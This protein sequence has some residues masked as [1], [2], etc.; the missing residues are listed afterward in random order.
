MRCLLQDSLV[1]LYPDSE[2]GSRP[3][4]SFS[5]DVARGGI[6]ATTILINDARVG[7]PVRLA[8]APAPKTWSV[9]RLVD[10]P[11][12]Q[13]TGLN[14][15]CEKAGV[16]NPHAVRRAPF[17]VFDAMEPV[18][19]AGVKA[20]AATQ[21]LRI[22]IPI[23][24]T[25]KPGVKDYVCT[26]T[27]GDVP[28]ILKLRVTVHGAVIP[29]VGRISFP[30]TNWYHVENMATRHGLELW[31]EAHWRMIR[32]YA[33]LMAHGR[34]NAFIIPLTHIFSRTA[35]GALELNRPRLRRWVKTFTDAGLHYIEGGHFGGRT[36]HAWEAPTFSI[37]L[38]KSLAT[39]PEG[40]A[41]IAAIAGQL[42]EEIDRN[43]WWDRWIQHVAD[44]PIA[45][46]AVDYRLF[47]GMVRKYMPGI[48]I[49]D[50][51]MQETLVGSVD[52]WCPQVS[53]YQRNRERFE[54]MQALGDEVWS[55]TCCSPGGPWLNRLL[56]MELLRPALIG[57][58][59][60]LFNLDGFLHWGLNQYQQQQNPFEMNVIP[61]WGGGSNSLPPGDTH[62]VYPGGGA[63][64]SSVRF[65]S[66]REGFEDLELLRQL[67]SANPGKARAVIQPVIRGFDDY[68]KDASVLRAARK[69]LLQALK[70]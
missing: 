52:M 61:N 35:A 30:Y 48:P 33:D 22:H 9:F 49:L 15:F 19:P 20:T 23:A 64:W 59:S 44:E 46:N 28:S 27:Q 39:G 13:N 41:D 47:V 2:V 43:D 70:G 29:P 10:V 54:A 25:A 4:R 8:L 65:E 37:G 6:A 5:L 34:Q 36:D 60:A 45:V 58:G 32:R 53:S 50:A 16:V 3:V 42:M 67:Q 18:D 51:T 55:Y 57:W 63:P 14:S 31:S 38:T 24:R 17:R 12:E 21:A 7:V 11:V 62:V 68:T 56:D 69:K 66:H 1:W 26:V 40:N